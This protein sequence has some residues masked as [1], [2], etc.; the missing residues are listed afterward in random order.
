MP[1]IVRLADRPE[2]GPALAAALERAWPEWYGAGGRAD[3]A[4]E[5]RLRARADGLP[6]GLLAL[7]EAGEVIGT[8]ALGERSIATHAHL[9]P[10]LVGLWVDPAHRRRGL[11]TALV[12]AARREAARLGLPALHA[13]TASAERLFLEDG[14]RRFDVARLPDHPG[15]TV[16]VLRCV[17]D[18]AV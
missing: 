10:W 15:E 11:G 5:A 18:E 8:V 9:S 14:W 17:P 7:G 12:R 16:A 4:A 6:L 13:A 1:R 3:P 2:L